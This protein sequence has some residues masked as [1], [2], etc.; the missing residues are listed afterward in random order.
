MIEAKLVIATDGFQKQ[1]G[2][3]FGFAGNAT[4]G[5]N[6]FSLG[7]TQGQTQQQSGM[8]SNATS[9]VGNNLSS[10]TDSR[11]VTLFNNVWSSGVTGVVH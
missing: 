2:S 11:N 6:R 3:K 7:S 10:T 1:L 9:S 5:N 4:S 8:V